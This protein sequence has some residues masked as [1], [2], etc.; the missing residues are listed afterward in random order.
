MTTETDRLFPFAT[1]LN[2]PNPEPNEG[3]RAFD[4]VPLDTETRGG[5]EPVTS[6]L[7]HCA[8]SRFFSFCWI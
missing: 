4:D 8:V 7:C 5:I 2:E 1:L 6:R 3:L